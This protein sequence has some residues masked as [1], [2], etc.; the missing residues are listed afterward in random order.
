MTKNRSVISAIAVLSLLALGLL[1]YPSSSS[2]QG[3]PSGPQVIS[4][5]VANG[6]TAFDVSPPLSEM[7]SAPAAA[8]QRSPAVI[9]VLRPKLQQLM[10]A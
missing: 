10:Q 8:P 1:I 6:P 2:A 3:V 4:N 9:P 5:A 7:I